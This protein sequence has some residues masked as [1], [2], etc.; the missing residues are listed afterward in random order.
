MSP[1]NG[2][3]FCSQCGSALGPDDSFCSDCGAP[4]GSRRSNRRDDFRRRVEDHTVEGWDVK[5]DYGDRVVLIDRGFGS[6]GVHALLFLFTWGFGNLLY[7]WYSYS[8]GADRIELR[9]DGTE[10][11]VSGGGEDD[12][13]GDDL[14]S[15][16]ASY[17]LSFLCAI[18]GFAVLGDAVAL[19]AALFG[20]TCLAVALFAFP[21]FRKRFADRES[22]TTFGRVRSTDEEV[23]E[24]P[25]VPCTACSRPV[26]TG[27][28]RTFGETLY[29]AGLPISTD[30]KGE[31]WYCRSCA[32]GDPFT[33]GEV[34]DSATRDADEFV[35]ER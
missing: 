5:H 12:A 29:V 27:V 13:S 32:Q 22:V 20:V 6:L 19:P 30:E 4:I 10:R 25:D 31:N 23:V 14:V 1:P 18:F 7:A 15:D 26:G 3:N 16:P 24:A 33:G 35:R 11:Y 9:A 2:S 34:G 8:P 17:F 21:P 28:K